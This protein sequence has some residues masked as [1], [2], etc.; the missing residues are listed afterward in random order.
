MPGADN[1]S[2]DPTLVILER[3]IENRDARLDQKDW[4]PAPKF[5]KATFASDAA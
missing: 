2:T 5:P 3:D 4:I 1:E